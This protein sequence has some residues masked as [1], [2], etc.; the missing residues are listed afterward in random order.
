V[1]G[2]RKPNPFDQV[3]HKQKEK[4]KEKR[5]KEKEE[6]AKEKE[7]K[8]AAFEAV[9]GPGRLAHEEGHV[10]GCAGCGE[11]CAAHGAA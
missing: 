2:W 9:M 5:R 11:V 6:R 8:R 4:Q 7:A 1:R 10:A 3:D